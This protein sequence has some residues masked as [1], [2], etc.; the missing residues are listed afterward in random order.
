MTDKTADNVEFNRYNSSP[1]PHTIVR[2]VTID[3]KEYQIII[4]AK[5][6]EMCIIMVAMSE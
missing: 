2:T 6:D 1:P 3:G 4:P 5:E